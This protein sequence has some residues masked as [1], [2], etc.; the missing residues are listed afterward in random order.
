MLKA[1]QAGCRYFAGVFAVGFLLGVP[2][3]LVL[4]PRVGEVVAVL[5][6]L[7]V[8]LGASWLICGR[9]LQQASLWR[10]AAVVMGASA[11]ALL[12]TAELSIS[13]LLANRSLAAH[14]ALYSETAHRLGLAGQLAFAL[15]PVLQTMR[16]HT[17]GTG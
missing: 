17:P 16:R 13:M 4:V 2:R 7:P 3:T 6:E 1:S 8:I 15:F 10:V 11:L 14:L 5:I 12:L 9:I